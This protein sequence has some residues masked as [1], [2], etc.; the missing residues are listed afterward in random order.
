MSEKQWAALNRVE[1]VIAMA[2]GKVDSAVAGQRRAMVESDGLPSANCTAC[3]PLFIGL[4][5]DRGA[6]GDSARRYLTQ[7]VEM[8]G[9]GRDLAD[10]FWL[11]PVLFQLGDSYEDANDPKHATEYHGQFVD[12]WKN[13][14]PELQPRVSNARARIDRLNRTKQ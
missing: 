12:L 13:A 2:E 8:I 6:R 3:N 10:R 11:A 14:D 4:A 9:S 7:Y 1:G 5:Y